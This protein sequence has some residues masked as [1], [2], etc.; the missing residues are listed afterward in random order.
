MKTFKPVQRRK[1]LQLRKATFNLKD[2][3]TKLIESQDRMYAKLEEM[4]NKNSDTLHAFIE[5]GGLAQ[6]YKVLSS[7]Y[8]NNNEF[9]VI[10]WLKILNHP[11]FPID[12]DL[13]RTIGLGNFINQQIKKKYPKC[14]TLATSIEQKWYQ[15]AKQETIMHQNRSKTNTKTVRILQGNLC[16]KEIT[17]KKN[18]KPSKIKNKSHIKRMDHSPQSILRPSRT[19]RYNMNTLSMHRMAIMA[20]EIMHEEPMHVAPE[21]EYTVEYV[22]IAD[23]EHADMDISDTDDNMD[24][25][26]SNDDDIDFMMNCDDDAGVNEMKEVI[27]WHRPMALRLEYTT[28]DMIFTQTMKEQQKRIANKDEIMINARCIDLERRSSG[29]NRGDPR[30]IPIHYPHVCCVLYLLSMFGVFIACILN[31]GRK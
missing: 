7:M 9:E 28:N 5:L 1:N 11:N 4:L 23:E 24:M 6:I 26:E 18:D 27:P 31:S 14:N 21:R 20:P 8:Q 29:M 2:F 15:F 17:F 30:V 13:I 22:P 10:R 19:N 16:R 3:F 12:T 25:S